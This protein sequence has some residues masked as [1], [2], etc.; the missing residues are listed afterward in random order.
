MESGG[1]AVIKKRVGKGEKKTEEQKSTEEFN[2]QFTKSN[3][4]INFW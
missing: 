4:T 2:L 1:V 3:Y